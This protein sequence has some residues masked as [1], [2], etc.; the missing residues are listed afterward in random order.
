MPFETPPAKIPIVIRRASSAE[1]DDMLNSASL[2]GSLDARRDTAVR[3]AHAREDIGQAFV[4]LDS[5][6]QQACF[7]QWLL[8]S[9][10]N[11]RIQSFF[12]R[13]FPLLKAD[14]VLFE[15]ALTLPSFRGLGIMS[16]AMSRIA[17]LAA[18]E[19]FRHGVTFVAQ[20]NL[21]S[22]RACEK[23]GFIPHLVRRDRSFCMGLIRHRRFSPV[24]LRAAG[25]LTR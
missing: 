25:C 22:L 18:Q 17:E 21:P 4:A 11:K 19:G 5:S 20:D 7:I 8:T 9:S 23:A 12:R 13:R 2:A 16:C 15:N 24:T 14:E 1:I 10:D 3:R 6:S